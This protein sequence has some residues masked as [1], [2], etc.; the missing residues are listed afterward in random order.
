KP[1]VFKDLKLGMPWNKVRNYFPGL[2]C[3]ASKK[4]DF[5]RVPGKK[6]FGKIR[7]FKFTFKYGKLKS[8]TI[9]FGPRLFD[10]KR[11][12]VAIHNVAQRKWGK[13]SPE[14]M[15]KRI[16]VWSNADYDTVTMSYH[17]DHWEVKASM[18][19]RDTGD[20]HAATLTPEQMSSGLTK[21]LGAPGNW[22]AAALNEFS[23]DMTCEQV[24]KAYKSMTGH[25]PLKKWS[26][27]TVTIKN[28]PLIHA[29]KFSFQNGH[30]RN[31][32]LVFHR[33]LPKETFKVIS[34][35]AFEAKW[36]SVRAEKRDN[37]IITIYKTHSGSAQRTHRRDHWEIKFDFP[38]S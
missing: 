8:A 18:P 14:K 6:I 16:K 2:R 19:K 11:F 22:K 1:V 37:D 38:K 31:A 23:R 29:L 4:Y 35:R 17:K 33:Q 13:L 5:P 30:L 27:G 32:T 3:N 25:N 12:A 21:L 26:F 9:V 15:S 10:S 7:E 20:V 24:S 36:G 28:H 34:L